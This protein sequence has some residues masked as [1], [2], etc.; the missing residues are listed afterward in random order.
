[1]QRKEIRKGTYLWTTIQKQKGY[2]KTKEILK[3]D[4]YDCILKHPQVVQSPIENDSVKKYFNGPTD[5]QVVT[6]MLL[7]VYVIKLYNIMVSP[8]NRLVRKNNRTK[9]NAS[10]QAGPPIQ[11][12]IQIKNRKKARGRPDRRMDILYCHTVDLNPWP[13]ATC[14]AHNYRPHE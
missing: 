3:Q 4:L 9:I 14:A 13:V 10:R 11:K 7:Q 8:K 6:N 2:T 1:M 12:L 5:K